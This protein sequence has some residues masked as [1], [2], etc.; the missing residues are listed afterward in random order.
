MMKLPTMRYLDGGRANLLLLHSFDGTARGVVFLDDVA[1]TAALAPG[2]ADI[3]CTAIEKGML[4]RGAALVTR[5][6][7]RDA[8]DVRAEMAP[9]HDDDASAD[10]LADVRLDFS[11]GILARNSEHIDA[12]RDAEARRRN[13]GNARIY[14]GI[15]D[16]LERHG[17]RPI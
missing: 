9:E 3:D 17:K 15:V 13:P 11:L 10:P 4:P 8:K 7:K 2:R 6:T 14:E 16:E 5:A 12:K 1:K